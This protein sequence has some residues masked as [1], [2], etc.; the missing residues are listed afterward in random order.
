MDFSPLPRARQEASANGG[1]LSGSCPF[2]ERPSSIRYAPVESGVEGCELRGR[3]VQLDLPEEVWARL[4]YFC[5]EAQTLCALESLVKL[6]RAAALGEASR[7]WSAVFHYNFGRCGDA[8]AFDSNAVTKHTTPLM[9]GLKDVRKWK[10]RYSDR[11]SPSRDRRDGAA[12]QLSPSSAAEDEMYAR[13][14]GSPSNSSKLQ[15]LDGRLRFGR[16]AGKDNYYDPRHG[17]QVSNDG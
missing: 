8:C 16:D 15:K 2:P 9:G 14:H 11:M 12:A 1:P 4:G 5:G 6:P 7:W 13:V 3:F 17:C 10:A